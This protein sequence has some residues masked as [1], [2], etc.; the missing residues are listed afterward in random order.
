MT[1]SILAGSNHPINASRT[2]VTTGIDLVRI[3]DVTA[4]IR[5]FGDRYLARIFT[6]R[7]RSDCGAPEDP[8]WAA[9]LAA[10]FAAAVAVAERSTASYHRAG[11]FLDH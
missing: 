10:R 3:S 1:P 5:R 8:L 7:E 4:S 2:M 11:V 9:R 6:E